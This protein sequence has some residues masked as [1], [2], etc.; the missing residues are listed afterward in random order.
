MHEKENKS[1]FNNLIVSRSFFDKILKIEPN[2]LHTLRQTKENR[3]LK[4][5]TNFKVM[6]E[7]NTI[8]IF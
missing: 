2:K 3:G 8:V 6:L 1:N 4:S 5:L 7:V